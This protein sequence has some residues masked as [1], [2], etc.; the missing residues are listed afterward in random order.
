MK[1]DALD[2]ICCI[3]V[4]GDNYP[5]AWSSLTARFDRPRLVA[6][7]ILEKLLTA[8]KSSN[9]TLVDFNKF[10]VTFDDGIKVLESVNLPNL[11]DF[12]LFTLASR[13][14]PTYSGKLFEAQLTNGFP[15]V[16]ELLSFVK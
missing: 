11:G 15:T 9:E 2:A 10:V 7:S 1:D 4:S 13:C 6:S 3:P 12:I 16:K 14:L 5:L 8:P